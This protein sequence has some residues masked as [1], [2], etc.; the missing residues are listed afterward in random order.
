MNGLLSKATS[1]MSN[2]VFNNDNMG[3]LKYTDRSKGVRLESHREE[4]RGTEETYG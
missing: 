4:I 3:W 1:R 2:V